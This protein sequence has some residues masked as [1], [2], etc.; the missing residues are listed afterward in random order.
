MLK[1]FC[2][3]C[4]LPWLNCNWIDFKFLM[5]EFNQIQRLLDVNIANIFIMYESTIVGDL[6]QSQVQEFVSKIG[7]ENFLAQTFILTQK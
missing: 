7:Q 6:E 3:I 5:K 4:C 1:L 2:A